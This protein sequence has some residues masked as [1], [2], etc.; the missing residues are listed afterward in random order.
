MLGA[1]GREAARR[2]GGEARRAAGAGPS[3]EPEIEW[4]LFCRSVM[5]AGRRPREGSACWVIG[6]CGWRWRKARSVV[7]SL[8]P[9]AWVEGLPQSKGLGRVGGDFRNVSV[10]Y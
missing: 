7:V 10:N 4:K 2:A 6:V 5:E 9:C 3:E 1:E 8:S